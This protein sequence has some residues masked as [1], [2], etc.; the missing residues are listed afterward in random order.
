MP[1]RIFASS[2]RMVVRR[3]ARWSGGAS[4]SH[5]LYFF[6]VDFEFD[7]FCWPPSPSFSFVL[8]RTLADGRQAD[9]TLD[10]T[11]HSNPLVQKTQTIPRCPS[12]I[13]VL[14]FIGWNQR[15]L[16]LVGLGGSEGC[17]LSS[18]LPSTILCRSLLVGVGLY[19]PMFVLV[20]WLNSSPKV[21]DGGIREGWCELLIAL[22]RAG[23]YPSPPR[24]ATSSGCQTLASPTS[25]LPETHPPSRSHCLSFS[26]LSASS[27]Q[28]QVVQRDD[29]CLFSQKDWFDAM[30]ASSTQLLILNGRQ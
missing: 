3:R 25:R 9:R 4:S 16:V 19:L 8:H 7:S 22:A 10:S 17:T 6:H 2:L 29:V 21:S 1:S 14:G 20:H 12:R 26:W 23:V 5:D 27:P 30:W 15:Q 24:W 13:L 11:R 28:S 18:F